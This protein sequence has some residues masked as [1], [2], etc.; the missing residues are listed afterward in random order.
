MKPFRTVR[1]LLH[2]E[3]AKLIVGSATSKRAEYAFVNSVYMKLN[4]GELR[5]SALVEENKRMV[6]SSQVC[7]YCGSAGPL[8]WEHIIPRAMNGPDTVDNLVLACPACN[9]SKGA[10]DP[11]AWYAPDRLDAI[12]RLVL[13]K[14]LK[15]L[16][17]EYDRHGLLDSAS[18]MREQGITRITL[19]R[20]FKDQNVR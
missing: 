4:S 15:L 2:W 14:L 20:I 16:H 12:P 11:Y 8:Q 10:A 5:I 7:A 17:A 1:E 13:G 3:Y 9:R 18:Y 19:A 6:L